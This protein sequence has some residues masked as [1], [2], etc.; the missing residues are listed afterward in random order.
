M[1]EQKLFRQFAQILVGLACVLQTHLFVTFASVG[2]KA[3]LAFWNHL[4]IRSLDY[5]ILLL[6][7]LITEALQKEFV[8]VVLFDVSFALLYFLIPFLPLI[9][10]GFYSNWVCFFLY[11]GM[12]TMIHAIRENDLNRQTRETN[13]FTVELTIEYA[14][15][16]LRVGFNILRERCV[17]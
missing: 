17:L 12:V 5:S 3:S 4:F 14:P 10:F 1:E 11:L 15:G 16:T 8:C 2:I 9:Y 7:L 13:R 6:P